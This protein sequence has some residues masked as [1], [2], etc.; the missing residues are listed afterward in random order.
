MSFPSKM[1]PTISLTNFT[2]PFKG[3]QKHPSGF[4]PSTGQPQ[5]QLRDLSVSALGGNGTQDLSALGTFEAFYLGEV[6]SRHVAD[7]TLVGGWTKPTWKNMLVKLDH[8]TPGRGENSKN[9]LKP[10]PSTSITPPKIT[11]T[12]PIIMVVC[13]KL[14]P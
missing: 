11:V 6:G 4:Q 8:E 1:G 10:P 7:G 12:S 3:A 9:P 13:R 5:Q 14:G 2:H